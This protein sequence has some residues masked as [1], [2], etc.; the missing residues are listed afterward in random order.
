[1]SE[2]NLS[3]KV[4]NASLKKI[5]EAMN[6][7]GYEKKSIRKDGTSLKCWLVKRVE[8]LTKRSNISAEQSIMQN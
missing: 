6:K 5:G 3:F 4:T 8:P 1:L 2:N 7:L